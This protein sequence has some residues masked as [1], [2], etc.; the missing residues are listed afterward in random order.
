MDIAMTCKT[1]RELFQDYFTVRL[2]MAF[3]A[4]RYILVFRMTGSTCY[5]SVFACTVAQF[6][7]YSLMT[8]AAYIIRDRLRIADI[9][10]HMNGMAYHAFLVFSV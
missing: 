8:T 4:L 3:L 10:R 6:V 9:Q 2:S 1:V 7:I 5:R